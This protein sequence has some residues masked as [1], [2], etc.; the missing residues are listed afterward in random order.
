MTLGSD[1]N[2]SY[3]LTIDEVAEELRCSREQVRRMIHSGEIQAFRIGRRYRVR[4][5]ELDAYA[6]RTQIS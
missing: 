1:Q 5:S 2:L 4:R 6:S 3:S